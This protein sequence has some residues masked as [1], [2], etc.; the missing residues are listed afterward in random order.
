MCHASTL[1]SV[2][3]FAQEGSWGTVYS[4]YPFPF[5]PFSYSLRKKLRQWSVSSDSSSLTPG[6][7]P[8]PDISTQFPPLQDN[9]PKWQKGLGSFYAWL[10]MR[11]LHRKP[12]IWTIQS[13]LSS[14]IIFSFEDKLYSLGVCPGTEKWAELAKCGDLYLKLQHLEGRGRR[15][16]TF[17]VNLSY[18]QG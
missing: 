6:L 1:H 2:K 3:A 9:V 18:I 7:T 4:L 14:T 17:K 16:T 5:S 8:R 15:I 12:E 11:F 10:P 13:S